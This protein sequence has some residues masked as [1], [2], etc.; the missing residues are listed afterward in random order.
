MALAEATG[1][2]ILPVDSEHSALHQLLAGGDVL[3]VGH[4]RRVL[5]AFPHVRLI[6]GYGPTEDTTFSCCRTIEAADVERASIPIWEPIANS[7]AYVLDANLRPVPF[8]VPGEL[9]VGGDGVAR[10][11]LNAPGLTAERYLPDPFA[12]APGARMYRTGDRV[13]RRPDGA[14]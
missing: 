10:G 9:Y 1:A 4:V 5:D 12:A 11:Y 13:R 6:N 2:H 14:I 7:T 8:D 3:S